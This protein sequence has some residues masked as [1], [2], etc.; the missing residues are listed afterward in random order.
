[1]KSPRSILVVDD[2]EAIRKALRL[3]LEREGYSVYAAAGGEEALAWLAKN[4]V[5]VIISDNMMPKM[6]GIDFLSIARDRYPHTCRIILTAYAD[7]DLAVRAINDGAIYRF[8]EKPWDQLQLK[9]LLHVAFEQLE[10]EAENRR[11]LATVRR[12]ADVLRG[13]EKAHP[14]ILDVARDAEGTILVPE[15]ESED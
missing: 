2:E 7:M 15:Q 13:L 9:V 8:L 11:L 6:S 5:Q 3:S 14:G 1:M 12:Q 10:L 4:E